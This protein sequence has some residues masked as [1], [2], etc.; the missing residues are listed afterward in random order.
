MATSAVWD[1]LSVLDVSSR[2]TFPGQLWLL[3][4]INSAASAS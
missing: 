2:M 1:G 3:A 4:L